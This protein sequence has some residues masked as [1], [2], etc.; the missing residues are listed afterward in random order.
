MYLF[1]SGDSRYELRVHELYLDFQFNLILIVCLLMPAKPCQ[2]MLTEVH[3]F[4]VKARQYTSTLCN[5]VCSH[6]T[7]RHNLEVSIHTCLHGNSRPEGKVLESNGRPC[8][9][10]WPY[11]IFWYQDTANS[12]DNI[13]L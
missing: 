8:Y 5:A 1:V 11:C 6:T 12:I 2:E 7:S 9:N 3:M 10:W 4:P 13:F